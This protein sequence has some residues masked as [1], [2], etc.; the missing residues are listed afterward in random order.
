MV[1]GF[2][3]E[4]YSAGETCFTSLV[5]NASQWL[6]ASPMNITPQGKPDLHHWYPVLRNG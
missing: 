6:K 3:D 2:V 4:Y 1:K 5:P